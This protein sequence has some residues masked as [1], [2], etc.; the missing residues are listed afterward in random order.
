MLVPQI[1]LHRRAMLTA[2]GALGVLGACSDTIGPAPE[3]Q[4]TLTVPGTPTA[5]IGPT[6]DMIVFERLVNAGLASIHIVNPDGTGL[7]KVGDGEMPS[8]SPDHSKI[9]FVASRLIRIMNADGTGAK[10]LTTTGSSRMPSF[11][12]D[13]QKIVFIRENARGRTDVYTVNVD[14]TNEQVLV[15]T[16]STDEVTPRLSPDGTKLAYSSIKRGEADIVV[17]DLATGRRSVIV[18]DPN[19]QIAPAWSPDGK[20][21][22]FVT[23]S[24]S[25]AQC[26]GIIDADGTNRKAFPSGVDDCRSPSWSPDGTELAFVSGKAGQTSVFRGKVDEAEAPTNVSLAGLGAVD[27][28]PVWSR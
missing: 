8:W 5:A 19:P 25:A 26:I 11:S 6:S 14:G 17:L 9:V 27:A 24:G 12:A 21:L 4:R 20:R 1:S 13:G 28:T 18:A 10:N 15:R 22:A 16:A 7:T 3:L 23:G 2:A